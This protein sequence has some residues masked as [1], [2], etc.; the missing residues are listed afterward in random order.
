MP[1]L[2][3]WRI[4]RRPFLGFT[5]LTGAALWL[6]F[7]TSGLAILCEAAEL[8]SADQLSI[9]GV[10]GTFAGPLRIKELVWTG[11]G[12]RIRGE[13]VELDWY[14]YE[15]ASNRLHIRRLTV[16]GLRIETQA[17]T[18]ALSLP[19]SLRLPLAVEMNAVK[20]GRVVMDNKEVASNLEGAL[21]GEG[22]SYQLMGLSGQVA[23][24]KTGGSLK[25][26]ADAPF[27]LAGTVNLS[28]AIRDHPFKLK[29]EAGGT[30]AAIELVATAS[31]GKLKGAGQ[32]RL[33][34]FDEQ[35]FSNLQVK[36]RGIDP[37]AWLKGAPHASL[38]LSAHIQAITGE[39]TNGGVPPMAGSFS[40]ENRKVERLDRQ[41]LPL[42]RLASRLQWRSGRAVFE[43]LR[44]ELAGGGWLSGQGWLE[45]G[46]LGLDLKAVNLDTSMLHAKL[47]PTRLS[48]SLTATLGSERQE[49]AVDLKQAEYILR[50]RLLRHGDS[51]SADG[52]D[53]RVGA[54]RLTASAHLTGGTFEAQGEVAQ[55][56]PG[57]FLRGVSGQLNGNFHAKG[58]LQ[59]QPDFKLDFQLE[60]SRLAELPITGKGELNVAWPAV[61]QAD[62]RLE[63]GNNW[64]SASGAFGR[65]G[66]NLD[67]AIQAPQLADLGLDGD[68]TGTMHLTGTP[69][70]PVLDAHLASRKFS[71]PGLVQMDGMEMRLAL[72][73]SANDRLQVDVTLNAAGTA[74]GMAI[75][76]LELHVAGTRQQHR[77]TA[78]AGLAGKRRLEL[79]AEGGLAGTLA[80]ILWAGQL[81]DLR[82]HDPVAGQDLRLSQAAPLR[83]GVAAW[84]LGPMKFAAPN[85]QGTL[86]ATALDGRL[87]A[88]AS[89]IGARFGT[90]SAHLD[91]ELLGAWSLDREHPWQGELAFHL[92]D[93]GWVGTLLGNGIQTGGEADGRLS[94]AGTPAHPVATGQAQGKKLYLAL[95]DQ[96]LRLENG[97]LAVGMQE[98]LLRVDRLSFDSRLQAPPRNVP[99]EGRAD[100]AAVAARPGRLEVGGEIQLGQF[101]A[102]G[103]TNR[104]FLNFSL[105]RVGA[106]Q[107]ADQWIALSGKGRLDWQEA[108]LGLTGNVKV[109]AG[110]WQLARLGTPRLSDDVIVKSDRTGELAPHRLDLSLDVTTDLGEHFFFS[111][112]GLET[113]LTGSVRLLAQ[114]RDLPK[115]SGTIQAVGGKFDAYGQKLD[116]ERGLINFQGLPDNPALNVRA[117]RKGL[118]VEAGV[119]VT[120]TAKKPVVR[121]ISDPEVPEAEKLSWLVLGRDSSQLGT[122]DAGV[123]LSAASSI[124]GN[125]SAGVVQRLKQGFG[126]DELGVR[127]GKIGTSGDRVATSRVVSSALPASTENDTNSQIVTVGKHLTSNV[128][129]SYEQAMG[130]AESMVKLTVTL[131]RRLSLV[132]SAG[133]DNALDLFYTWTFGK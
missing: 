133:S 122:S 114:G 39:P 101:G 10:E 13:Q 113:R 64:L 115:A 36:F 1:L 66:D 35:P 15:L 131:S 48:G 104:A 108:A 98:N 120:G 40:V 126:V 14:P 34:P 53:L 73:A 112:A 52:I 56:D 121:L 111:G 127:S 27:A 38:D 132:G 25:I 74:G 128:I 79:A 7:S 60:R 37:A 22:N 102:A 49:V 129:L 58:R 123:L 109:D 96:G 19:A 78:S 106:I 32:V 12:N 21:S 116:V 51:L 65:P 80:S 26:D 95:A 82:L 130:K 42:R 33:T 93:L 105:E 6:I 71:I 84:S 83:V 16:V 110:F 11:K 103:G 55:F 69:A 23:E 8:L 94:L 119:E 29:V 41:G 91:A 77:L 61:R 46:Q 118:P 4:L 81:T 9:T 76:K 24:V 85:W 72:G 88:E 89:G 100:F 45:G 20:V 43:D 70:T 18:S 59:P 57:R 31:E 3:L 68:L 92:P 17:P 90:S 47:K 107:S 2:R 124:L 54:A 125:N 67:V 87:H 117:L 75:D 62:V 99:V 86:R 63:V 28:G 44:A 5:L 30:L 97:I 50:G